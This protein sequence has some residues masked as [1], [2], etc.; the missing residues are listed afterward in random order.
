VK[1]NTLSCIRCRDAKKNLVPT[2]AARRA[3][4]DCQGCQLAFATIMHRE[5]EY[6]GVDN[7]QTLSIA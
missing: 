1:C 7:E 3:P 6:I 4:D 2:T 5:R